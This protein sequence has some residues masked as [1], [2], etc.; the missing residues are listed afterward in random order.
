MIDSNVV[1]VGKQLFLRVEPEFMDLPH[2]T[3]INQVNSI[4]LSHLK[5]LRVKEIIFLTLM[6][7][8]ISPVMFFCIFRFTHKKSI[9]EPTGCYYFDFC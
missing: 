3:H 6:V 2:L 8:Q 4:A 5:V 9:N 7:L 1:T